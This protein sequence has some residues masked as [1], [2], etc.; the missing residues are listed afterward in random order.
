MKLKL[1]SLLFS[2]LPLYAAL[3][4]KDAIYMPFKAQLVEDYVP[5]GADLTLKEGKE[6]IVV[7]LDGNGVLADFSRRGAYTLPISVTNLPQLIE[8]RKQEFVDQLPPSRQ[9]FFFAN[10]V[11]KPGDWE[12]MLGSEQYARFDRWILLYGDA[13]VDE[14]AEAVR[15][16]SQYIDSLEAAERA[17]TAIV[18]MDVVGDNDALLA[19]ANRVKPSIMSMPWYLSKGY[20]KTLGHLGVDAQL[21]ALVELSGSGAM[22]HTSYGTEAVRVALSPVAQ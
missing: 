1:L 3:S 11:T 10:R 12:L 22:L 7:R 13:S 8:A 18:Y 6:F 16:A 9:L 17:R 2:A 15:L 5:Q 21:P 20:A 19:L 14:T 4:E